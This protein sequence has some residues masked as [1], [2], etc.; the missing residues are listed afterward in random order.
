MQ[1]MKRWLIC[2]R[3][4]TIA[5][6]LPITGPLIWC[7]YLK[8]VHLDMKLGSIFKVDSVSQHMQL[9]WVT[10]MAHHSIELGDRS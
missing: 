7:K 1:F 2:V 10:E 3:V 8:Y 9:P 4:N 5:N 6:G